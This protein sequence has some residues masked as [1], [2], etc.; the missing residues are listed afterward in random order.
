M[1]YTFNFPCSSSVWRFEL[2][3]DIFL[4]FKPMIYFFLNVV[5]SYV[6]YLEPIYCKRWE[7]ES[8]GLLIVQYWAAEK[9]SL[10]L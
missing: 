1:I 5:S 6:V 8:A 10:N 9:V 4:A 3:E 2:L 7:S